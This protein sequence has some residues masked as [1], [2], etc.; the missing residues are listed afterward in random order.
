MHSSALTQ[1]HATCSVAI[2]CTQLHAEQSV[3]RA[4]LD[5][6]RP[7]SSMLKSLASFQLADVPSRAERRTT[8]PW[9]SSSPTHKCWCPI[10]NNQSLLAA[11]TSNNKSLV[12]DAEED[13]LCP[14]PN[15]IPVTLL[16]HRMHLQH[17]ATNDEPGMT[18]LR[19]SVDRAISALQ[20]YKRT[21]LKNQSSIVCAIQQCRAASI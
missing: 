11:Q 10:H 4:C 5:L 21:R 7:S 1:Q 13:M 18:A 17:A 15:T 19:A 20:V 2:H 16:Q 14:C 8:W 3:F 6:I 12:C 9:L